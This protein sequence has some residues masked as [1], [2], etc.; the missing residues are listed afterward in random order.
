MNPGLP[1]IQRWQK[2]RSLKRLVGA[3]RAEDKWVRLQAVKAL[4]RMGDEQAVEGL[5]ALLQD[6]PPGCWVESSAQILH[7][8]EHEYIDEDEALE[9]MQN[10]FRRWDR[11]LQTAVLAA[12]RQIGGQAASE[13][14]AAVENKLDKA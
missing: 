9:A 14:L 3:L 11:E 13:A 4:G 10:A 8:I 12:L 5:L 2:R 7:E 6:D 1:E